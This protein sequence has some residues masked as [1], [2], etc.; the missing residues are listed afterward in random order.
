MQQ[1][2]RQRLRPWL[3]EQIQSGKYPGVSWLDQSA[4]IF[5]IP[6]KH[7][8]RHG[9]SIDRDATLFRSWAMHTGRYRPGRD[10]PDPKTWKA[11]FR[12][13]LNSLPDICELREHSRKRGTNAY[14]VYRILPNSQIHRRRKGLRLFNCPQE[15]QMSLQDYK[16]DDT[17]ISHTWQPGTTRQ[18]SETPQK[19]ETCTQLIFT[20]TEPH[21]MWEPKPEEQE[22]SETVH[23]LIDHFSSTDLWSQTLEQRE[24]RMHSLWDQSHCAVDENLYP[25]HAEGYSELFGPNYLKELSDWSTHQQMLM[26]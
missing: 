19:V 17:H 9:W 2:G 11:N 16:L 20:G 21:G 18:I 10:K 5:Q 8:A 23:K 24:W 1:P 12:C 26:L 25:P 6:W 4:R 13:A 22:H 15:R 14:R 7:A 3:E